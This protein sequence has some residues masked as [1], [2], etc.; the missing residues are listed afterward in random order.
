MRQ[1]HGWLLSL[2]IDTAASGLLTKLDED[3]QKRRRE[4]LFITILWSPMSLQANV[5]YP[6]RLF[7][8]KTKNNCLLS[9]LRSRRRTENRLLRISSSL[10]W[11]RLSRSVIFFFQQLAVSEPSTSWGNVRGKCGYNMVSLLWVALTKT[12]DGQPMF[13]KTR[14]DIH[15]R[16]IYFCSN[17]FARNFHRIIFIASPELRCP[18]RMQH[19]STSDSTRASVL[20]SS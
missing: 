11:R 4:M 14:R 7:R 17:P 10:A 12:H 8:I 16:I 2:W 20:A 15:C 5:Y 1:N 18:I 13:E 9:V 19:I 3:N 6:F